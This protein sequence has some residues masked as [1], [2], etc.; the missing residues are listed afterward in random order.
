MVVHSQEEVQVGRHQ[1][2]NDSEQEPDDRMEVT[3][4]SIPIKEF[5]CMSSLAR[6]DSHSV[7]AVKGRCK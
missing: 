5:I 2:F 3:M 4:G 6:L 7:Y 1:L